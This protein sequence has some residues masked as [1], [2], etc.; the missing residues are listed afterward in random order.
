GKGAA[1]AEGNFSMTVNASG[2]GSSD[3][4][5]DMDAA[6]NTRL[7]GNSDLRTESRSGYYAPAAQ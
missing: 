7:Q 2:K 6:N 3:M 5:A 4:Q 1:D